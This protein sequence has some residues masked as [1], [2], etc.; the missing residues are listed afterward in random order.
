MPGLTWTLSGLIRKQ[1]LRRV[2][3]QVKKDNV[4]GRAAQL[5]YYFL[6]ALFPLLLF[7]L[8][9]LG[10][11]AEAGSELRSSLINYLGTVMPSSALELVH[12]TIDEISQDKGGGKLSFGLLAALWAASNGMNAV[13]ETLNVAY[14]LEETRPWWRSRAVAIGLTVMLAVIII[15]ALITIL[16]GTRVG[17]L[18]AVAAGLGEGFIVIWQFLQWPVVL[19]FILLTFSLIYYFAPN[20]PK[21][22][23]H[24]ILPGALIALILWILVSFAFR[25]Y[26]HFFNSYSVTYGSLG[27][28]IVLMLWFYFTGAAILIGGEVNA[29]LARARKERS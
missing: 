24:A 8:T 12:R 20:L 25:L 13:T 9:L 10:Y 1:L 27:A 4:F 15:L 28:L 3:S 14:D 21:R 7:L 11:F 19:A 5:S 17:S 6:L 2:W 16:L 18:I 22:S 23:R 26:L 29:E